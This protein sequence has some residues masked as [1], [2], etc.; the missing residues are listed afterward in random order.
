MEEELLVFIQGT[1]STISNKQDDKR[2]VSFDFVKRPKKCTEGILSKKAL[3]IKEN[4]YTTGQPNKI[5]KSV[6]EWP[7]YYIYTT[8]EQINLCMKDTF[9][10]IHLM[11]V[12]CILK[13]WCTK[14]RVA[15][16]TVLNPLPLTSVDFMFHLIHP[17]DFSSFCLQC[18]KFTC[19]DD[20][21]KNYSPLKKQ[22]IINCQHSKQ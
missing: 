22:F 18:Q 14:I 2:G 11:S 5:P 19:F 12:N 7:Q 8:A 4:R 21:L 3:W 1:L 10:Q 16:Y 9:T 17:E 20:N 13:P 15:R 6:T